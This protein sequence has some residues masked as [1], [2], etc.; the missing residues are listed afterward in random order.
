MVEVP[1]TSDI[2][3]DEP[4]SGYSARWRLCRLLGVGGFAK[5]YE[6]E[7]EMGESTSLAFRRAEMRRV[8]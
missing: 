7:D 4:A 5:V 6:A 2:V 1:S 8:A 3:L